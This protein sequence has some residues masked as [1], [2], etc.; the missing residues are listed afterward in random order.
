V[1]GSIV[2]VA[3]VGIIPCPPIY[4]LAG[5]LVSLL[6]EETCSSPTA[7]GD[8]WPKLIAAAERESEAMGAVSYL[9]ACAPAQRQKRNALEAAIV[10]HYLVKHR[11]EVGSG[12]T[13]VRAA[14]QADVPGI[15]A[16]N[17]RSQHALSQANAR[18]WE[19]HPEAPARFGGWMQHSL[20]LSDR[21]IFV[22]SGRELAGFIIAQRVSP[23]HLPLTVSSAHLGLVDDFWA[24]DFESTGDAVSSTVAKDLLAEAEA[25]LARRGRTSAMVIVPAVRQAKSEFLEASGYRVANAWMLKS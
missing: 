7:P 18:M 19:P 23:F 14:A 10:T 24:T 13:S 15:V 21:R 2:A 8:A 3:R 20:T 6:F 11:L 17:A 16:L 1:G 12:S 22:T 25:E 9:A 4:H 5:K